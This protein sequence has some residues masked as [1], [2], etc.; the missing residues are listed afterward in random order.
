MEPQPG[1]EL[2]FHRWYEEDHVPARM[3]LAG[4]AAATR[5]VAL[6]GEPA[7]AVVYDLDD[8][9]VLDTSEYR[10]L[11]S[12]PSAETAYMLGNAR[13]FTRYICE[14]IGDS[15]P[16]GT[17]PGYLSVVA[18]AVAAGDVE[19]FDDWYETEHVPTLL[20]ADAWLRVRR[21]AVRSAEG[22]SWNRLA[23]HELSA[24]DAMWSSEREAAR[25]TPK[26]AALA[27][28]PWFAQSGRWVYRLISRHSQLAG[29]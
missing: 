22:G 2:R 11:K 1:E 29:G 16:S 19:A 21:L 25:R 17:E 6:Q 24:L 18:F 8:L 7:F 4:F 12:E 5:W 3:R 20:Q 27:A 26:R 23:L 15:G 10:R 9:G 14:E 13:A 28:C